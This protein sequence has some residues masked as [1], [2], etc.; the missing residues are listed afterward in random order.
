VT[1]VVVIISNFNEK[2]CFSHFTCAVRLGFMIVLR[3]ELA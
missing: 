2:I 3:S 1:F